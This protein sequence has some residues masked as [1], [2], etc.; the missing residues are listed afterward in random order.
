MIKSPLK[1]RCHTIQN[2]IEEIQLFIAIHNTLISSKQLSHETQTPQYPYLQPYLSTY[3]SI[4]LS[5]YLNRNVIMTKSI[6][7]SSYSIHHLFFTSCSYLSNSGYPASLDHQQMFCSLLL[8]IFR[9]IVSN[10]FLP[11]VYTILL[12][13]PVNSYDK[14]L[15]KA[16]LLSIKLSLTANAST[17]QI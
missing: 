2:F 8:I 16:G 6:F 11:V 4:H 12:N 17:Y 10:C 3:L 7:H 14:F 9:Y 5:I 1:L 15:S 13:F